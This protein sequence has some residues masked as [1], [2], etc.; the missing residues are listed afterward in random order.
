MHE[1]CQNKYKLTNILKTLIKLI[2]WLS[3]RLKNILL[4]NK[5]NK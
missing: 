4:F 1:S 3:L 5:I 2:F